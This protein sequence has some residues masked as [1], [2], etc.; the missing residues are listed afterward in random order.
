MPRLLFLLIALTTIS[1]GCHPGDN[2]PPQTAGSPVRFASMG[3]GVDVTWLP[4]PPVVS[5]NT[6]TIVAF[7]TTKGDTLR[8]AMPSLQRVAVSGVFDQIVTVKFQIKHRLSTTWRT[9]NGSG[10]GDATTGNVEFYG[11]YLVK[12]SDCRVQIVTGGTGPT[13]AE[14]DVGLIYNRQ[15]GQ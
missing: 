11:D 3:A 12:G 13:L 10:S 8:G 2:T 1:A 7:D 9:V 6:A 4:N 15:L 14:Y 5:G